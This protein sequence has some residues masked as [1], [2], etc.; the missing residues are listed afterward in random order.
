MDDPE[1]KNLRGTAL[2]AAREQAH[3]SAREL[4]DRVNSRSPGAPVTDHAIYSYERGKV[5][6]GAAVARRLAEVLRVPA[7]ELLIGDPD[8]AQGPSA[9]ADLPS[10]R[11]PDL[12]P[13]S[14]S[15]DAF[16][17]GVMLATADELVSCARAVRQAVGALAHDLRLTYGP[18]VDSRHFAAAWTGLLM[19]LELV[20]DSTFARR[21]RRDPSRFEDLADLAA[22]LEQMHVRLNAWWQELV[23]RSGQTTG[24]EQAGAL[25]H[26][27]V[28]ARELEKVGDVLEDSVGRCEAYAGRLSD[29]FT[30]IGDTECL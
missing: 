21:V 11:G 9:Q 19:R 1:L 24:S 2:R 28:V 17:H 10:D 6:L 20:N 8:Y 13:K 23:R 25:E 27:Q 15:R 26:C 30:T 12:G 3:L 5:C 18:V 16:Q 14:R 7:S 4:A 29:Q 22:H